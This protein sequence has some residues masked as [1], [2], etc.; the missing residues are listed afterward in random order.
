MKFYIYPTAILLF[1]LVSCGETEKKTEKKTEEKAEAI[2][3]D[4]N[5]AEKGFLEATLP[6]VVLNSYI[7]IVEKAEISPEAISDSIFLFFNPDLNIL[8]GDNYYHENV[9]FAETSD[10]IQ[11]ELIG[12]L[13]LENTKEFPAI[14]DS[15]E[16]DKR[17][18]HLKG[19][20][21]EELT[22]NKDKFASL[23]YFRISPLSFTKDNT[24]GIYFLTINFA[25]HNR[26]Y[27]VFGEYTEEG[28]KIGDLK[29]VVEG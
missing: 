4:R 27:L 25:G 29:M 2:S 21:K 10:E 24:L 7:E 3:L 8:S 11:K 13:L 28:W 1:F 23:A 26:G 15:L 12:N 16:Y 20:S 5:I 9:K 19:M 18:T 17:F 14:I 22:E 6:F